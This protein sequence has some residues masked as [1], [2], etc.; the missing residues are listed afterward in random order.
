MSLHGAIDEDYPEAMASYEKQ[1][2][3]PIRRWNSYVSRRIGISCRVFRPEA[4]GHIDGSRVV[5]SES[6]WN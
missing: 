6:P 5:S 2:R 4:Q 3:E 1:N